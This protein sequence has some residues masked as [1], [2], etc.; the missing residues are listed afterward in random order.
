LVYLSRYIDENNSFFKLNKDEILEISVSHLNRIFP[1]FK[2]QKILDSHLFKTRYA[3][4]IVGL[5]YSRKIPSWKSPLANFFF[6][7]MAQVYPE[8]RGT[9]YAVR[10]GLQAGKK[11]AD[12]VN[13]KTSEGALNA[14]P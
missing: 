3:Q 2:K 1:D 12:I 5:N 10:Q 8:D 4:P 14:N 6:E 7:T 11:I 13:N 9:N